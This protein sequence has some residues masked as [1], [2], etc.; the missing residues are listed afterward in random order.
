MPDRSEDRAR[1]SEP[2][3]SAGD[4]LRLRPTTTSE[5]AALAIGAAS[6]VAVAWAHL[7]QLGTALALAGFVAVSTWLSVIDLRI[8]RLPNAIVG[9]L[10]LAVSVWLLVVTAQGGDTS[11]GLRAV[12]FGLGFAAVLLVGNLAGGIGMGDVKYAYPVGAAVGWF[13]WDHLVITVLVMTAAGAVVAVG[14][15]LAGKGRRYR[16]SY[17]P[18]M[19]LGQVAGLLAAAPGP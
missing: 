8:H 13:G 1:P 9:P 16:M 6:T 3:S 5:A 12:G 2:A 15:L 14:V 4:A 10:A 18:Y 17:G 11:R 7:E 19:A